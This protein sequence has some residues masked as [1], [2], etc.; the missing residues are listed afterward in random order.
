MSEHRH[1]VGKR[2][3][4]DRAGDPPHAHERPNL[5]GLGGFSMQTNDDESMHWHFMPPYG[6]DT[7]GGPERGPG[8]IVICELVDSGLSEAGARI[9]ACAVC[10]RAVWLRRADYELDPLEMQVGTEGE[11]RPVQI[12]RR[13]GQLLC[14]ECA[15]D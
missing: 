15:T 5:N 4:L 8:S 13:A 14:V 6:H 1:P 9:A 12:A 11:Q 7:S 3:A 2:G 10:D